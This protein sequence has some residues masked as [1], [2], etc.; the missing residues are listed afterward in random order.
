M[1]LILEIWR[2][3]TD[4]GSMVKNGYRHP[5]LAARYTKAWLKMIHRSQI[6]LYRTLQCWA[7]YLDNSHGHLSEYFSHLGSYVLYIMAACICWINRKNI[8]LHW[9]NSH[10]SIPGEGQI[11]ANEILLG[12]RHWQHF[13][14][15]KYKKLDEFIE[16]KHPLN[17]QFCNW[18]SLDF[19]SLASPRSITLMLHEC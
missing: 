17:Q 10:H 9:P 13:I 6:G 11:P 18:F 12:H 1:H 14:G 5:H 16:R 2:Y 3:I 19:R 8:M 7:K 15:L 4:N